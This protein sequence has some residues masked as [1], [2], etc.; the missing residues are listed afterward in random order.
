MIHAE[1]LIDG[2]FIGG[3]CDQA[4][5]K[6]V[7]RAPYGGHV[8]GSAAEGGWEE[9][10]ACISSAHQAFQTWKTSPRGERQKLLR[11]IAA[12]VRERSEEL[13]DLLTNE[14]AKP[15]T[16]SKGEVD[17]LALTFDYAADLVS[18]YGFESIPLDVDPRGKGY[19]CTVERFPFGP[20]FCMAPYNWPFNLT[21]HKVAPALATGNTVV[22][23]TSPLAPL[24]TLQLARLIHECGAP[25]GVINAWNGPDTHVSKALADPRIKMLSFTGSAKVGWMLKA[26]VPDR[27][28]LVE[29][30]GDAMAIVC[31][32]ADLDWTTQRLIAGG[33]GYAGQICIS[34]QH[35]LA[36]KAIYEQLKDRLIKATKNCPTGDPSDPKTVCGPLISEAA[37]QKVMAMVN[38]AVQA[39]AKILA[40]GDLQGNLLQPT[41]IETVPETTA[42]AKEEV[43]GPVLTL[44]SFD[45]LDQAI[46]RVNRSQYGI[47]AGIFTINQDQ[48]NKAY[49]EIDTGGV[50]V[51]DYPTLRFDNMPYGGVKRSGFGREGVRYA[52]DEMTEPKTLVVRTPKSGH[53]TR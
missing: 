29:L 2:H 12:T 50:I 43:F 51:N 41:L 48:A 39:G 3:P 34:V 36:Q 30:G 5:G 37:A 7:V 17:R 53:P 15:V 1:M 46:Q 35:V 33:Y 20:I 10:E 27:K 23:K 24:C 40:G 25:P 31:E 28:V 38:E 11:R 49:R 14:I 18:T 47:Q 19:R 9:L 42:L 44:T 6:Q 26:Q 4:T 52:M 21:A 45:T 13:T 16:W 32:D 22:I 8:V